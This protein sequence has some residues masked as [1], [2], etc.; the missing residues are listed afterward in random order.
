MLPWRELYAGALIGLQR[1]EEAEAVLVELDQL[2]AAAHR[3]S[4]AARAARVRAELEA[5]RGD[6]APEAD[7]GLVD[8]LAQLDRLP[9]P[10]EGPSWRGL[11][12][13]AAPPRE[14]AGGGRPPGGGWR[15]LRPSATSGSRPSPPEAIRRTGAVRESP[16]DPVRRVSSW[17]VLTG[18]TAHSIGRRRYALRGGHGLGQKGHP[19]C[20]TSSR[21][22][23]AD[24]G[25]CRRPHRRPNRFPRTHDRVQAGTTIVE[26]ALLAGR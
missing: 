17:T 26:H 8:A 10:L 25:D 4:T 22:V 9:M 16:S 6:P 12:A 20:G 3:R 18:P 7:S 24:L 15:R 14:A 5:A 23:A 19:G 21:L 11:R 1:L 2:A 13:P